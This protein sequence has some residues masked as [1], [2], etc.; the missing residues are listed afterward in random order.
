[1]KQADK[2]SDNTRSKTVLVR[3]TVAEKTKLKI[4][5]KEAGLTLSDWIRSKAINSK[6]LLRK[7]NPD[8]EVLLRLLAAFGKAGSNLNQIAR[9]LNRRQEADEFEVPVKMIV[10][11]LDEIKAVTKQLRETFTNDR[12]RQG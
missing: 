2:A 7:T 8:R 12:E 3:V 10:F 11:I 5:S 4:A 6:P 1:M 9:Q